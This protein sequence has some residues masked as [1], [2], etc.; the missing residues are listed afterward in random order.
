LLPI[1]WLPVCS[2]RVSD[3]SLSGPSVPETD[4]ASHDSPSSW[5]G[6][7]I[8]NFFSRGEF[9]DLS[10]FRTEFSRPLSHKIWNAEIE[11]FEQIRG[12]SQH[13]Q[14]IKPVSR[15]LSSN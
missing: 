14:V 11:K 7:T 9:D 15:N 4:D 3:F 5:Q 2:R 1:L 6:V 10:Q 12:L 8:A 13:A